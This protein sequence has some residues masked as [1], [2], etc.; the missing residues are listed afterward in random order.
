VI[1]GA[2]PY[3]EVNLAPFP[4]RL[5]WY[6]KKVFLSPFRERCIQELKPYQKYKD[7]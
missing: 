6:F 1:K 3:T 4:K 5:G 7:E 2:I